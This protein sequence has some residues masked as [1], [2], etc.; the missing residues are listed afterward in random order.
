[1]RLIELFKTEK[2]VFFFSSFLSSEGI[3]NTYELKGKDHYALWVE[4]EDDLEK[5]LSWL[6]KYEENPGDPIFYP[7]LTSAPQGSSTSSD[8]NREKPIPVMV[9]KPLK[10]RV[11]VTHLVILL[12]IFLFLW[13]DAEE[14]KVLQNFGPL[15][16]RLV[17]VPVQKELLF[18]YT[19]KEEKLLNVLGQFP[20]KNYKTEKEFPKEL[21]E[22]LAAVEKIPS[23]EG[24]V[25]WIKTWASQGLHSALQ[26]PLFERISH[27]EVWRLFTPCL[28]HSDFLHILFNMLWVWILLPQV[29]NRLGKGRLLLFI[30]L[31]GIASN[32]FQYLMSGPFFIGFSGVVVG[33]VCFIWMRQKK[34]PWEGYPLAHS[35][36]VFLLVFV[37]AMMALEGISFLLSLFS[38][39][40]I[41]L[42]VANTAHVVGGLVGMLLGR[43]PFFARR[44]P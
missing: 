27:G 32:L 19:Q 36:I 42:R 9:V 11:T 7:P 10:F 39:Y 34:A 33:L 2:E 24:I 13:N 6:K 14:G 8:K 20:L 29:E 15:G 22:D 12:C 18:D 1:M 4:E 30:L 31:T 38:L 28:L 3:E 16:V 23:Y 17:V 5:A 26:I 44:S 43:L 37:L 41:P 25:S 21:V 35:T 40:S